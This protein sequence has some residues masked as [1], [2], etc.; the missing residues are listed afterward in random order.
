MNP[1]AEFQ[2]DGAVYRD[3]RMDYVTN[4]PTITAA[5]TAIFVFGCRQ[6]GMLHEKGAFR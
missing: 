3:D 5:A 1:Y 6:G 4:E 2:S